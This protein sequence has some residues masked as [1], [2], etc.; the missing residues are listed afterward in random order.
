MVFIEIKE[1]EKPRFKEVESPLKSR[2]SALVKGIGKGLQSIG[3]LSPVRG[4]FGRAG[5][6]NVLEQL[7]PSS[8]EPIERFTERIAKGLTEGAIGGPELSLLSGVGEAIGQVGKEAGAPP[9]AQTLLSLIPFL[10]GTKGLAI[11]KSQKEA[12]EFLR[13]KGLTDKEI[14]PL[15]KSEKSLKRLGKIAHK[16]ERISSALQGAHEKL[17]SGY[18][19]LKEIGEK[20][21]LPTSDITPFV[22]D[23]DKTFDKLTPDF[24]KLISSN[25]E[26]L[27]NK[28]V[29]AKSLIDFWQDLNNKMRKAGREGIVGGREVLG[30]LKNPVSKAFKKIDPLAA[31]D[32]EMLNQFYAKKQKALNILQPK[33]LDHL[34]DISEGLG[35]AGAILT[36]DLTKFEKILGF[37]GGRMIATELLVNPKL[38]NI[39]NRMA[40]ALAKNQTGIYQ[41]LFNKFKDELQKSSPE[42]YNI[43]SEKLKDKESQKTQ[44]N[45]K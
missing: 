29:S 16:G 7:L 36:G 12:V 10:K 40:Q 42:I 33:Q 15:L 23:L 11:P 32:F 38:Q 19:Q 14:V 30:I 20:L 4:P 28:P 1:E 45:K 26:D 2:T 18:S 37:V 17:G 22:G 21:T 6:E 39:S 3:E 9:W 31:K 24:K 35:L 27:K 13:S 34:L 5:T 44:A 41:K 8:N 25:I 43:V